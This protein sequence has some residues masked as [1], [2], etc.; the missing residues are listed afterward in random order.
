MIAAARRGAVVVVSN[1]SAPE[2]VKGYTSQAARAAGLSVQRVAARRAINSNGDRR[3]PVEELIVTNA[4]SAGLLTRSAGLQ[5][6]TR[7]TMIKAGMR[8]RTHTA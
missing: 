2:I 8:R 1:S 3:G 4:T 5:S 7:P 6:K